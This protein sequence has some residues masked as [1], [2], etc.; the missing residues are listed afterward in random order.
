MNNIFKKRR[1]M[2]ADWLAK[3]NIAAAIFY[4]TEGRRTTTVRY[5]TGQP[6]DAIYVQAA[7]G[8]AMLC[9]W[10]INLAEKRAHIDSIIPFVDYNRIATKAINAMLKKMHVPQQAKIEISPDT[11]Y[12]IFL[13][14]VDELSKYNILC[15]K[16]GVQDFVTQMQSIKDDYEI[17]CTRKACSITNDLIEAIIEKVKNNTIKTELDVALFIEREA[18]IAGCEGTGF[19]T[20][21]A[22]PERSYGIHC[23]PPYTAGEWASQGLS[24]LDFGVIYEGY[25]SDVTMTIARGPL[26][27]EQEKQLN[28]VQEAYN[29]ALPLYANGTPIQS[30][31]LQVEHV[32]M[33]EKRTMPHSLGHG[34]GLQ[35]HEEPFIRT[36]IDEEITF[37]AGMIV[38]LEPGLYDPTIGGC[39]LENDILILDE[40]SE[41]LTKSKIFRM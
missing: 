36:K 13:S 37:K 11:P 7:D 25:T 40:K 4:D 9:P 32:F 12:P 21:A 18:R 19:D 22:G 29:A 27:I 41:L 15:R 26:T 2:L 8:S 31:A 17:D 34:F 38:T 33:K 39:R 20:L 3:N 6:N 1:E 24:I 10:D 28:L 30:A 35:C 14:Y 23:F 5:F 16:N